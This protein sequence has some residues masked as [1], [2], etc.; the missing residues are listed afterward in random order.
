MVVKKKLFFLAMVRLRYSP[1]EDDLNLE[2]QRLLRRIWNL[3]TFSDKRELV[4]CI[5]YEEWAIESLK[6][7]MGG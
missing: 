2:V 7:K 6:K 3:N 4:D 1:T 5:I